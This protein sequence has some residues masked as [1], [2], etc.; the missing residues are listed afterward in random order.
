M[1]TLPP[2]LC[3]YYADMKTKALNITSSPCQYKAFVDARAISRTFPST[4]TYTDLETTMLN[5]KRVSLAA[6][7]T[8]PNVWLRRHVCMKHRVMMYKS[9]KI[10]KALNGRTFRHVGCQPLRT[11]RSAQEQYTYIQSVHKVT[12]EVLGGLFS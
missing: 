1:K 5:Y 6:T 7:Q 11:D 12:L 8:A 3:S 9:S 10:R 4:V 2:P